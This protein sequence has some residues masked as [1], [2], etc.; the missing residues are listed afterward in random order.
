VI[1]VLPT[2]LISAF[3]KPLSREAVFSANLG[4]ALRNEGGEKMDEHAQE[5][6]LRTSEEVVVH[7]N[8]IKKTRNQSACFLH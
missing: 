4:F 3:E 6:Y 5:V 1:S 7:R 2:F 8:H